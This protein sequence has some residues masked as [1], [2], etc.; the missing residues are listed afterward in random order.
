MRLVGYLSSHIQGALMEELLIMHF[1]WMHKFISDSD[2]VL[3]GCKQVPG[4]VKSEKKIA[5]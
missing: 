2:R 3:M 5:E 4:W 1:S